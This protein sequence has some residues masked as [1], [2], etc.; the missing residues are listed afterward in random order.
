MRGW[1]FWIPSLPIS[2]EVSS[3]GWSPFSKGDVTLVLG[4]DQTWLHRQ[5]S[6]LNVEVQRHAHHSIIIMVEVASQVEGDGSSS[7][8]LKPWVFSSISIIACRR[9]AATAKSSTERPLCTHI[10]LHTASSIYL[11]QTLRV[12]RPSD[13]G[14]QQTF[15]A[16]GG[17]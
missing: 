11:V 14:S 8:N 17:H 10:Y 9:L 12:E 13:G 3:S 1:Y 6:S 7:F 4:L 5:Q 15:H 2:S 16:T